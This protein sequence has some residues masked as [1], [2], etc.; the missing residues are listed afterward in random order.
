VVVE[1]IVETVFD[2]ILSKKPKKTIDIK[3]AVFAIRSVLLPREWK[4]LHFIASQEG[5]ASTLLIEGYAK[6]I[7]DRLLSE[8]LFVVH[9][10]FL[11][12]IRRPSI[13]EGYLYTNRIFVALSERVLMTAQDN[14]VGKVELC[15]FQFL[16]R[17]NKKIP[18][19]QTCI[20]WN[21]DP[22]LIKVFLEQNFMKH[23]F[24]EQ[25]DVFQEKTFNFLYFDAKGNF[26]RAAPKCPSIPTIVTKKSF[27][28]E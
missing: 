26:L 8:F 7:I 14:V 5:A 28:E 22:E 9:K 11:R 2:C 17:P 6:Q 27:Q 24:V 23:G 4:R 3:A 10:K 21:T 15:R 13:L 20:S 18:F 19:A 12:L 1:R 25:V 16:P